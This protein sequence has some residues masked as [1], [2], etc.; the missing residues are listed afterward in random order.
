[1]LRCPSGLMTSVHQTLSHHFCRFVSV[2]F[3]LL[4]PGGG[5]RP[6]DLSQNSHECLGGHGALSCCKWPL[7]GS[8]VRPSTD[9]HGERKQLHSSLCYCSKN[10]CWHIISTLTSLKQH[11][12]C[13]PWP[14]SLTAT[15]QCNKCCPQKW[16]LLCCEY[17]QILFYALFSVDCIWL[18]MLKCSHTKC[19]VRNADCCLPVL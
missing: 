18:Q 3:M 11:Q 19:I 6:L 10:C 8:K 4:I 17:D 12:D 13:K 2:T 1:M 16:E 15:K 7:E 9:T 5:D 14:G